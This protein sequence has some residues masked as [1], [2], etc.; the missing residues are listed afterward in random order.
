MQKKLFLRDISGDI[1]PRKLSQLTITQFVMNRAL[2]KFIRKNSNNILITSAITSLM[3]AYFLR[4]VMGN[5]TGKGNFSNSK[6]CCLTISFD[7]D[8]SRDVEA[9]QAVLRLLKTFGIK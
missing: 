2:M 1:M 7:C 8:Y 5:S 6:R 3:P 4:N 9:I